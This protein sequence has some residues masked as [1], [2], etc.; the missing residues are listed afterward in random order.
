MAEITHNQSTSANGGQL[1]LNT[2]S[3][4]GSMRC[5]T[6]LDAWYVRTLAGGEELPGPFEGASEPYRT[7]A[8]TL[9]TLPPES[10]EIALQGFLSAAGHSRPVIIEQLAAADPTAPAPEFRSIVSYATLADLKIV[11]GQQR[12]VWEQWIAQ[13]VLNVLASEPGTGKTRFA[14]DLTR[15]L[16][17]QLAL[18]DGQQNRLAHEARPV[19][20]RMPRRVL[21]NSSVTRLMRWPHS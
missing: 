12:W 5:P 9:S 7:F 15:R 17:Y 6:P 10:R 2:S 11:I 1:F 18:P 14:M 3:Q 21:K 16:Y 4:S 20:G 19:P 8:E 13:G